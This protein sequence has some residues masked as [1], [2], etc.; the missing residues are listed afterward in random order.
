MDRGE[1]VQTYMVVY[2]MK[3]IILL[4]VRTTL[5]DRVFLIILS[6]IIM[7]LFVPIFSYYSMRQVQEISITMALTLNSSILL[8]LALFGGVAT[9]WRDIERKHIYT[10]LSYPIKRHSYFLGRFIGFILIMLLVTTINCCVSL[11]VI[12]FSASTYPSQLPII[13][14]SILIS[15]FMTL[16]KYILLM[17]FGFMFSAFSTSFFTPFFSTIAMY[18][19]G[20]ASQG[21]YDY[22]LNSS[23]D[24]SNS[25]IVLI[26]GIY[27]I[28]PN[29]SSFDYVAYASYSLPLDMRSIYMTLGYFIIYIVIVKSLSVMIFVK[30]DM[31]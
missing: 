21:V 19:A 27:L 17:A 1:D 10:L 20:N 6:M 22:L 15:F 3:D 2:F 29:F 12:K 18:F 11:I 4:T 9:V 13:W 7:F 30:R 25:F 14:S 23:S 16:L 26:K 31:M 5:K 28:I 24:Y 8:F